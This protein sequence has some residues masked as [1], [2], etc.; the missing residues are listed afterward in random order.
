MKNRKFKKYIRNV[1]SHIPCNAKMRKKIKEDLLNSLAL[2]SEQQGS[3]DPEV[4]MGKP[5]DVAKE[6]CEN[7]NLEG[8]MGFEYIS[9]L[10]VFGFPLVHLNTKHGG[11]A[12]GVIAIGRV[13]VGIVAIGAVSLGVLSVGAI[14]VGLLAAIGAFSF[15]GIFSAGGFAASYGFS[16]GFAAYA[17]HFAMGFD[18]RAN[19]AFGYNARGIV[20]IFKNQGTGDIL[21]QLPANKEVVIEAIRSVYPNIK[22]FILKFFIAVI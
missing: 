1:L 4:L 11:T 17:I 14:C 3:D 20:S 5:A 6:F 2:K 15:S 18:A 13:A 19:I 16:V 9:P 21:I 8:K 22:D 7:L 10:K 12:K